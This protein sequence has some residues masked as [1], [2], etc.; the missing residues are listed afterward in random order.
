M[1]PLVVVMTT[2]LN[3]RGDFCQRKD[4]EEIGEKVS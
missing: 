2:I 3:K 4:D 1:G